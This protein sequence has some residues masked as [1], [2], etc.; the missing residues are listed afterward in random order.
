MWLDNWLW[1]GGCVYHNVVRFGFIFVFFWTMD[2]FPPVSLCN[3]KWVTP[4]QPCKFTKAKIWICVLKMVEFETALLL[5]FLKS[6]PNIFM[7]SHFFPW[8]NLLAERWVI[9]RQEVLASTVVM[10]NYMRELWNSI[11]WN[12]QAVVYFVF[13]CIRGKFEFQ[14]VVLLERSTGFEYLVWKASYLYIVPVLKLWNNWHRLW[15][16]HKLEL[17]NFHFSI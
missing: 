15:L 17:L 8:Q 12:L 3:F 6:S 5:E 4:F 1:F 10:W 16:Q 2:K 13:L 11:N 9:Q 14:N 7:F